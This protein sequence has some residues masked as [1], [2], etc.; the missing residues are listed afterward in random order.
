MKSLNVYLSSTE[1]EKLI[2]V[3][4]D[5]IHMV[6]TMYENTG[7]EELEKL[8]AQLD[9]DLRPI[10]YKLYKGYNGEK[11]YLYIKQ[12]QEYNRL[13]SSKQPYKLLQDIQNYEKRNML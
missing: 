13:S 8:L 12:G 4:N 2:D 5:Y 1:R 10:F 6:S 7:S 11:Y 9:E 3:L